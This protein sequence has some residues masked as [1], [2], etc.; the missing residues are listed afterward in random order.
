MDWLYEGQHGFNEGYCVDWLYEGHHGLERG[1]MWFSGNSGIRMIV[2]RT[3][4]MGLER[5]NIWN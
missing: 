3:E 5:Y 1:A 2:Y 4:S